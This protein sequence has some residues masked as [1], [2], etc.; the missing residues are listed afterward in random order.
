M[1]LGLVVIVALLVIRVPG[2]MQAPVLTG[3]PETIMLGAGM[4]AVAF[5]QTPDWFAVVTDTD[6]IL[7]F[8][9]ATGILRQTVKVAN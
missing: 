2:A 7:I 8:D 1:I 6:E 3:L 9:R 4:R 5:T